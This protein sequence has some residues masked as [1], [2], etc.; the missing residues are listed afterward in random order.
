[1]AFGIGILLTL[2]AQ[3]SATVSVAAVT[4][5]NVGL[6]TLDQ[7]LMIVQG[8]SAGSGLSIYLV[9]SNLTGMGRQLSLIQV[10]TK[11]IGV[12]LLL[13]PLLV[14]IYAGLPGPKVLIQRAGGNLAVQVAWLYLLL[15]GCLG[16]Y[17]QSI[18][19]ALVS[20]CPALLAPGSGREPGS[21]KIPLR[22][23]ARRGRIHPGSSRQ[24][25]DPV[26][27]QVAWVS[28][29]AAARRGVATGPGVWA[30]HQ[31][32]AAVGGACGRFL[33]ELMARARCRETLE[34]VVNVRSR[35]DLVAHLQ[36]GVLE[37]TDILAAP[38]SEPA[39]QRLRLALLEGLHAVLQVLADTLVADERDHDMLLSMSGDRSGLMERMR[40]DLLRAETQLSAEAKTRLFAATSLFERLIWLVHRYSLLLERQAKWQLAVPPAEPQAASEPRSGWLHG[41]A[42][43]FLERPYG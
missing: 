10:W 30:L 22:S 23:G 41:L 27:E 24:G 36:D 1:L 9:S 38:L 35:N 26:A 13:P 19:R 4:M 12:L 7:T 2:V 18:E 16:G 20:T 14:E 33:A 29:R 40:A 39:A 17:E 6:L 32:G 28:E 37:L 21:T 8:A 31:G 42:L 43:E 25:A 5:V 11:A 3:S 15:Q 34:R